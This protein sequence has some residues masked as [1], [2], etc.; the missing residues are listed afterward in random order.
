MSCRYTYNHYV[1]VCCFCML[2]P[3][4]HTDSM[5]ATW[6]FASNCASICSMHSDAQPDLSKKSGGG[7]FGEFVLASTPCTYPEFCIQCQ[8]FRATRGRTQRPICKFNQGLGAFLLPLRMPQLCMLVLLELWPIHLGKYLACSQA[9]PNFNQH[10]YKLCVV[11]RPLTTHDSTC[12]SRDTPVLSRWCTKNQAS[13]SKVPTVSP[14]YDL[15]LQELLDATHHILGE[16][17]KEHKAHKA[18]QGLDA[19]KPDA[20]ADE[21]REKFRIV[22]VRLASY[23]YR[24]SVHFMYTHGIAHHCC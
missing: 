12:S 22:R 1:C 9:I 24:P 20:D 18:P 16:L 10:S 19:L 15:C 11:P 21:L 3:V 23:T 14:L 7:N 8:T 2:E 6:L 17:E 13:L 5:L 4:S